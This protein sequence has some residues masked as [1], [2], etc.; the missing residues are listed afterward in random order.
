M[1]F[2]IFYVVIFSAFPAIIYLLRF[3]D[4]VMNSGFEGV[5]LFL[6]WF[7]CKFLV[8]IYN[9]CFHNIFSGVVEFQ[10]RLGK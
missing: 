5:V 9:T 7:F 8:S 4:T 3:F 6:D 2:L 1:R 10:I